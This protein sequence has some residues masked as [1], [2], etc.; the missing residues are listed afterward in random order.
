VPVILAN[1]AVTGMIIVRV[2]QEGTTYEYVP[3]LESLHG[4]FVCHD[5]VCPLYTTC[6]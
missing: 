2:V 6:E 3:W 1:S 5:L 4:G